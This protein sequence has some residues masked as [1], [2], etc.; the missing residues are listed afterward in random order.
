VDIAG[1]NLVDILQR[2]WTALEGDLSFPSQNP[3]CDLFFSQNFLT[4]RGALLGRG[5]LLVRGAG[6]S[7][8]QKKECDGPAHKSYSSSE[9]S[10]QAKKRM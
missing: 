9:L 8:K 5:A 10:P 3:F 6:D 4:A 7:R 2:L 1:R